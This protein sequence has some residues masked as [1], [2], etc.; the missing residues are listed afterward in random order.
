[1]SAILVTFPSAPKVSQTAIEEVSLC[2]THNL[3]LFSTN[4]RICKKICSLIFYLPTI[5]G[6][7]L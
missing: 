1:M 7:G 6:G 3:L 5:N 4:P 2:V